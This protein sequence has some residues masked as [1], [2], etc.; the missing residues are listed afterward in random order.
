MRRSVKNRD[1]VEKTEESLTVW[2][3]FKAPRCRL[4]LRFA[5]D[6]A[7]HIICGIDA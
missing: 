6:F 1:G 2:T 3:L 7:V 5:D 4:T